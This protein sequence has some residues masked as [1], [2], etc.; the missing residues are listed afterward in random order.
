MHGADFL[1]FLE[2][3]WDEWIAAGFR[4]EILAAGF[5]NRGLRQRVPK[6]IDGK[7]GYFTHSLETAITAGTWTAAKASA[8]VAQTAQ[9]IVSGGANPLSRCAAR[10]DIMRIMTSMAAIASSTMRQLQPK[11]SSWMAPS[12]SPFWMSMYIT[13][14]ARKTFST[15]ATMSCSS[16]CMVRRKRPIPTF[17]GYADEKGAGKGEGYNINY[18]IAPGSKY[19]VWGAA[20]AEAIKKIEAYK[21]DVLVVSLGV[22]TYKDDP[23][24]PL[25]LESTDFITYGGVIAKLKLPTLI[26]MEGGYA[27]EQIGINTVNM[28]EGFENG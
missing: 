5:P 2:T 3:C 12:V 28:L 13:A 27:V 1:H 15:S 20:L 11:V 4:G 16:R 26:V 22:D 21:P 9:K 24:S 23:I 14:T 18:P 25:K 6:V 17:L 7:V 8:S 10:R 19:D